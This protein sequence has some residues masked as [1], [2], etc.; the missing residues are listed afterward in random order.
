M[1]LQLRLCANRRWGTFSSLEQ[2]WYIFLWLKSGTCPCLALGCCMTFSLVSCLVACS[3]QAQ[4]F[5]LFRS[6]SGLL[7]LPWPINEAEEMELSVWMLTMS[8]VRCKRLFLLALSHQKG[9]F[10]CLCFIRLGVKCPFG[11]TQ[12]GYPYDPSWLASH[13]Y[14][15]GWSWKPEI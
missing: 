7:F 2:C 13:F 6:S 3:C 1:F 14:R 9:F 8:I 12:Y 11:V 4:C 5:C 15:H 10:Y